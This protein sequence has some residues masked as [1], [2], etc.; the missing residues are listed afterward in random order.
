M[1]LHKKLRSESGASAV[2]FAL[3]L[4][5]LMMIL[6]GIIEFGLALHRQAILTNASR[7]GA[8][9]G[10]VQS[11]TPID[12]D[13]VINYS[14]V[15]GT[16]MVLLGGAFVGI[17]AVSGR[18]REHPVDYGSSL[19]A[20]AMVA[21]AFAPVRDHLQRLL[22]RRFF[23]DRS[24]P[25]RAVTRLGDRLGMPASTGSALD[26]VVDSI[27]TSLRLDAVSIVAPDQVTMASVG[28]ARTAPAEIPLWFRAT[29]V[30][31]LTVA[32]R[33][34]APLGQREAVILAGLAPLVGAIVHAVTAGDALQRSRLQIVT[35]REEERRRIRRDLHDG[36]GPALAAVRMKLDAA[37]ILIDRDATASKE[38][39]DQLAD[40]VRSTIEDIR[41]LVYD[42]RPP[43]LDEIGL[44]S[45]VREQARAFSGPTDDGYLTVEV[46]ADAAL[47]GLPAAVEVA[48]YRIVNESLTNVVRHSHASRCLVGLDGDPERGIR[49]RIDD[50]GD[51]WR[52]DCRQGVGMQSM[53]ER[54]AELGGTCRVGRSPLG[55]T[56]IEARLPVVAA[57]GGAD[58]AA[59]RAA[60]PAKGPT[61]VLAS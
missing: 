24:D 23:G 42:L 28:T 59:D 53:V 58:R 39:L 49:L 27:A 60:D 38:V 56:R 16:L 33:R 40:D 55:G 4:P 51:G 36:L 2:E 10:I 15:Y 18:V 7:E 21:L 6:F 3:L 45:A 31:T 8:R 37:R 14:L 34:G 11:L 46:D 25:Y 22:D 50:D 30:G 44:V 32:H 48:V 54:A 26:D 57:S 5:V 52:P 41:R 17:I 43:A 19:V 9:A 61:D 47:T 1:S 35:T 12:I 20:A 29:E 13:A